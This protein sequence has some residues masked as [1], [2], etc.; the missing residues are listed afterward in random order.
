M[1]SKGSLKIRNHIIHYWVKPYE[2]GSQYGIENE[3]RISKLMLKENGAVIANYDR[4]WD[5]EPETEAA[6]LAYAILVKK[7]N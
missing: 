1:W 5:M 4:G 2:Q 3:G 7:Y 6:Q